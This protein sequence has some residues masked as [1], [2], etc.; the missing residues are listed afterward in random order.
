[1]KDP[2]KVIIAPV[3]TEK[4]SN[5]VEKENTITLIVSRDATKS[6]VKYAVEKL[7]QVK[8]ASVRILITPKGEKKAYIRLSPEFDAS[9]LASRLGIV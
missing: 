4:A 8:V 9:E 3:S 2:L 5:L 1:M 6:D 7:Y